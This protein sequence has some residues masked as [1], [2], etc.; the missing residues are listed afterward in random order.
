MPH[1][2]LTLTTDFGYADAYVG[3][4]KGVM[5]SINPNLALVDLTHA[6]PP[7]DVA[8]GAFVLG[9]AYRHF[10]TDAVHLAVVDP[11]VGTARRALLLLTPH[12]RFIAPDNGLL[13]Y[14]LRDA[15]ALD[16]MPSATPFLAQLECLVPAGFQVYALTNPS[17]WRHPVSRTFHARDVF[18]PAAAHL[19]LG[20]P[21]QQLGER[22]ERLTCL[23]LPLPHQEGD[24]LRGHVLH[25]DGFGNLVTSI[26]TA[27]VEGKEEVVITIAN[28]R[29]EGL[30]ASYADGDTLLAIAGSHGY[31][32]V[33]L[34][35]GSAAREL[36]VGRGE[37]VGAQLG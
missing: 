24:A 3:V 17:F 16:G 5:L 14:I 18:G 21:P 29:I 28:R 8:H 7:Q 12:G 19:S 10:P 13:S 36:G 1:S 25:V 6:V 26:P 2:V 31:V 20:V 32:E 11:G 27:Q 15:G 34:R 4:V 22:V 33:S 35:N 23:Y 37:G 9:T 30:S